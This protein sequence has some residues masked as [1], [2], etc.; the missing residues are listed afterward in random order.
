MAKHRPGLEDELAAIAAA[1]VAS[2]AISATGHGNVSLRVPGRDEFLF[3]T[4]PTLRGLQPAHVARLSLDGTVLE[5]E[6][7]PINHAVVGMHTAI[8]QDRPD[9]GCVLHTHSP[10]ATAFAVA[11]KPI[12]CWVEAM[13]MFGLGDGVPIADYGPRGSDQAV[14]NIRKAMTS[15]THAVLLANHGVLVFHPSARLAVQLGSIIEEAAQMAIYANALGGPTAIPAEM[16]AAALQRFE[17][18]AAQG[19]AAG[20]RKKR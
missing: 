15:A 13:A 17:S 10:C 18:F 6:L 2:G 3:S 14:A 16:R 11:G 5:G 4:A 9:T 8:Y 1:V 12:D 19:V 7:P 20:P